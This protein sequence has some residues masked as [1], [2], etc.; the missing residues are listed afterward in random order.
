[1]ANLREKGYHVEV[2]QASVMRARR[3][4]NALTL[5]SSQYVQ[6]DGPDGKREFYIVGEKEAVA[7]FDLW[8]NLVICADVLASVAKNPHVYSKRRNEYEGLTVYK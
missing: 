6:S 3:I 8:G 7:C 4:V 5:S 2:S 1:M